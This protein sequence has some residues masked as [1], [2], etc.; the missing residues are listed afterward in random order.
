MAESSL[1]G[2]CARL[3]SVSEEDDPTSSCMNYEV[4]CGGKFLKH[5]IHTSSAR[6]VK[7]NKYVKERDHIINLSQHEHYWFIARTRNG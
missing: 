6:V 5:I 7:K 1:S 3:D 2:D 4:S